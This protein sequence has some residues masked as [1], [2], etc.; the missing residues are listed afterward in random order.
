VNARTRFMVGV[1]VAI[2]L[3]AGCH[4]API[5]KG[6]VERPAVE[7][8]YA[9]YYGDEFEGRR[10]ASGEPYEHD[11]L[12]A[13]HRTLPFGTKIRVTH[14]ASG[15]SVTCRVNDRGPHRKGRIV[16]LSRRA[17]EELGMIREGVCKVTLEVLEKD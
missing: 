16:D 9:S 14:V 11:E 6:E 4:A 3:L 15:R 12:T 1:A 7:T 2:P 17:A 5:P 10:T 8:G 13:A